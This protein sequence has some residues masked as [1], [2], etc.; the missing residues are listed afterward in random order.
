MRSYPGPLIQVFMNIV[1]NAVLHAFEPGQPGCITIKA[2]A[3]GEEQVLIELSDDGRG[4]APEHL[5]HAFDP[6]FTTKLGQG[7]SGLGLHIVYNLVT[8]LLGGQVKL[9][10]ELGRGTTLSLVLPRRAPQEAA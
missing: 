2:S 10:S 9:S 6:F 1:N 5:A 3:I 7:G 4:M 8:G